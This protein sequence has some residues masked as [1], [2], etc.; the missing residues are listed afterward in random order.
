MVR[1]V[2]AELYK[3]LSERSASLRTSFHNHLHTIHEVDKT[4]EIDRAA[5]TTFVIWVP[6]LILL[7][8]LVFSPQGR[9]LLE[10]FSSSARART[11][12]LLILAVLDVVATIFATTLI[13]LWFFPRLK[14]DAQIGFFFP[15][16]A[17]KQLGLEMRE[18][19]DVLRAASIPNLIV[20]AFP[21]SCISMASFGYVGLLSYA[22]W[23]LSFVVYAALSLIAAR[24][25]TKK[26]LWTIDLSVN[27]MWPA[28]LVLLF[29][30]WF[31]VDS[32]WAL[33]TPIAVA[34]AVICWLTILPCERSFN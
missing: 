32:I 21:I 12:L 7:I 14:E 29:F 30:G 16:F 28:L 18:R 8:A 4:L 9:D 11:F 1:I 31:T 6:I 10:L 22:I 5:F 34:V 2:R 27:L 24:F 3:K 25:A 33:S 13:S 20:I 26:I 19:R 17:P 23:L 15:S